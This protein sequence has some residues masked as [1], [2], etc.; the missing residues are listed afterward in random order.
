MTEDYFHVSQFW[1]SIESSTIM[2]NYESSTISIESSTISS[3]IMGT[4]VFAS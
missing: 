3:T 2:G 1:L 4:I